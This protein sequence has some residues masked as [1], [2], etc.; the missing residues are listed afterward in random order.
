MN[1][2][3]FNLA[4]RAVP[5]PG[6]CRISIFGFDTLCFAPHQQPPKILSQLGKKRKEKGKKIK[7][8]SVI[9]LTLTLEKKKDK[10]R[11]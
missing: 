10:N 9:T 2:P 11:K 7:R 6:Q 1:A 3:L 8:R 4:S 5:L